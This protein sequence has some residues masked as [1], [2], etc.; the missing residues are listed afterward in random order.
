MMLKIVF[1]CKKNIFF[2]NSA[3]DIFLFNQF[4]QKLQKLQKWNQRQ[5]VKLNKSTDQDKISI[6]GRKGTIRHVRPAK[7]QIRL[8]NLIRNFVR[9]FLDSQGST[10]STWGQ[11]SLWSD[12]A[13]GQA[14]LSLRWV[15]ISSAASHMKKSMVP[16]LILADL[17]NSL[18]A[19]GKISVNQFS[20]RPVT[21]GIFRKPSNLENRRKHNISVPLK[22]VIS[23]TSIAR[24]SLEP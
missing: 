14:Y 23:R 2:F 6:S 9:S 11:V 5:Q 24:P 1:C 19:T 3:Y 12:C 21:K 20:C 22:N 17:S 13:D 8:R 4:R 10:V 18:S 15:H 7:I 16:A